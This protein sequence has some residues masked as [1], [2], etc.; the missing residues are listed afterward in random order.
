MRGTNERTN[1]RTNEWSIRCRR[2]HSNGR[3]WCL[4]WT[5]ASVLSRIWR[6]GGKKQKK[7]TFRKLLLQ[8][9]PIETFK[10]EFKKAK[11]SCRCFFAV[12]VKFIQMMTMGLHGNKME[13]R[14]RVGEIFLLIM[15]GI[16]LL[17]REIILWQIFWN[18]KKNSEK[19]IQRR[20]K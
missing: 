4:H 12:V 9:L 7:K 1:E 5:N 8:Q 14:R 20:S 17:L 19:K 16:L 3:K 15:V 11:E 13:R 2:R 18:S 6:F 10:W